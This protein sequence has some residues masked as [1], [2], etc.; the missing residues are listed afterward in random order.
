MGTA[1]SPP[2]AVETRRQ[3]KVEIPREAAL[4]DLVD[5]RSLLAVR[6]DDDHLCIDVRLVLDQKSRS[7]SDDLDILDQLDLTQQAMRDF[8]NLGA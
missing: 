6:I 8:L 5:L 3:Q 7:K 4:T 1:Q 2:G